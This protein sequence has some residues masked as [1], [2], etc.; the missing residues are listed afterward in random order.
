MAHTWNYTEIHKIQKTVH[1]RKENKDYNCLRWSL[2]AVCFPA[3][4]NLNKTSSYPLE[5][6]FNFDGIYAPTPIIKINKVEKQNKLAINVF[7][8]ENN[9]I[10]HY[11]LSK[12]PDSIKRIN[13]FFD[14]FFDLIY[15][16]FTNIIPQKAHEKTNI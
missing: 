6:D 11:R 3:R 1:Q 10:V 14:L 15:S 4:N 2:R 8:Y 13:L 12:Q 16:A 7:G 9:V 5:D